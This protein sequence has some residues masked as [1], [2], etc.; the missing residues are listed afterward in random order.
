MLDVRLTPSGHLALDRPAD[1]PTP[2]SLSAVLAAFEADWRG[3]LFALAAGKT[4]VDGSAT[5]RYWQAFGQRYLTSLCHLPES[6]GSP[7]IDPPAATEL[8]GLVQTAPPMVGG[9]YLSRDALSGIWQALHDWTAAAIEAAG[10]LRAFLAEHAPQWHQVGRVCF[11][12]AENKRD[13]ERPFAFLATFATGFGAGGRLKHLPLRRALEQY[14]G[15]AN[16]PALIKLLTPVDEAAKAC[17]WVKQLVDSGQVYQPLAWSAQQAYTFLQSVPA[18]EEAGLAV[19]VPDWWKKRPRPRVAVTIGESKPSRFGTDA[20]LDF[21][22]HVALGEDRLSEAELAALLDEADDA[23]LVFLRG[24]WVEVDREKLE[25]ALDH[26]QEVQQQTKGGQVTFIEGMR[27]LAGA[28]ADLREEAEA[29][30][31]RTWVHVEAGEALRETLSRLRQ[32]D[33]TAERDVIDKGAG[34][35]A[36]LRPY[37]RDGVRWMHM[38]GDLGL[39]ACLADDMGLGKTLQVLTLEGLDR[40]ANRS[41]HRRP[42]LLVVPASLLGNWQQEARRFTPK[43]K[44]KFLH[45]AMTPREE[46]QTIAENPADRLAPYDLAV[47]T[48]AMLSRQD[49]LAQVRWKRLVLDE[50]QAIKNAG[51]RQAKAVK[52]LGAD[53]RIA[54]TG[55]PIENRLGDLWSLFD[56]LNP[57]LLGS[58][59]LF[60]GFVKQLESREED[61]YGPLRRLVGPYIL[62]RLKTDRSIIADLPEKTETD[63]FCTLTQAQVKLY[64]QSVRAMEKALA[65]VDSDMA[66]RGL[67]LQTLMRLKQICN[68]PSQLTGDGE[69]HPQ[70][71]GKFRR[72]GELCEELAGRQEK[73]LIFTQFREIIDPLAAYLMAV[74]GRPGATLHGGTS[75]KQRRRVVE[76]FQAEDGPPFFILSLKAGGTGLNL[77]AASHVVHFDRWWNPAVENQ[78]T[79]RAFRIGQRRNVLV[80][81]FITTGTVE[82]RIDELISDKRE[83]AEQLL[84]GDGG[85]VKLTEL[86]DEQ[87][88]QIVRLDAAQAMM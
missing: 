40:R 39:G 4:A 87:I 79:D 8:D 30:T 70:A 62:R 56:F 22:A 27:M 25:Q 49:W 42:S 36:T 7:R 75:V 5:L 81:K 14:A 77:T 34:V 35:R 31:D 83:L 13:R 88:M 57:G 23:G 6:T 67:V 11:H 47:T 65:D 46:L 76:Q 38:L 72:L 74:F 73:V 80:H 37:Q 50:A 32:P 43:L 44:L 54:L 59:K 19:R 85:E 66:R 18:L 21:D 86:P 24:Q 51:T 41:K 16:K 29:E 2:R 82:Q 68:H 84:G 63:Q 64:E 45:P 1:G 53:A 10:G 55:T 15:A 28:S 26:W 52:K 20:L 17:E 69:Y 12:L 58:A 71:S 33:G 61:Q 3:G 9:E 48:Y 78:A 60:K